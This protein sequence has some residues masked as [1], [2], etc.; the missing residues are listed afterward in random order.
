M[1]ENGRVA[2]TGS[3]LPLFLLEKTLKSYL[4][5]IDKSAPRAR[6]EYCLHPAAIGAAA[7]S[8]FLTLEYYIF[9]RSRKGENRGNLRFRSTV[10]RPKG[11]APNVLRFGARMA[12]L[13]FLRRRRETHTHIRLCTSNAGPRVSIPE[14]KSPSPAVLANHSPL[15]R[16]R[17]PLIG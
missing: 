15:F 3:S 17:T 6:T 9:S 12:P 2:L 10:P 1:E 13:L 5:K 14:T 8:L 11:A 4:D 7:A 16:A